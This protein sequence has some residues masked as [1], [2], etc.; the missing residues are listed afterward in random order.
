LHADSVTVDLV[1][2]S[3][4]L[5]DNKI[6]EAL[7][8]GRVAPES[9]LRGLEPVGSAFTSWLKVTRHN[10]RNKLVHLLESYGVGLV[11]TSPTDLRVAFSCLE[12]DEIEPLFELLHRALQELRE[13]G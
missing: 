3:Q 1:Q 10:W 12:V 6:D 9:I 4:H 5:A 11:A 8:E 2:V 7:V 13:D